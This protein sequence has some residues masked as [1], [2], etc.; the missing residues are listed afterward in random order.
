[1]GFYMEKYLEIG[2]IINKR[3]IK[4][5]LKIE[6]Y[7]N[8]EEDFFE[9]KKIYLSKNGED[10]R[11]IESCK[12][13]RGFV[14]LKISGCS[15]PE[16]ADFLRGKIIYVD[17]D[18]IELPEDEVFI[19]DIIG[20]DVIDATTGVVYGKIK[21]VVN[22]GRYDT[23][24]IK[25]KDKEY[26]MPAVDDFLDRIELDKGVYVTPIEGLFDDGEISENEI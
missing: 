25:G 7:S 1:M 22:Y 15:T 13:Y 26:M 17:R 6:P 23:Y 24:I 20:L 2:K 3:G 5:E 9:Y 12:P 21:D 18:D 10:E 16:Q 19:A 11:K 8:S 14:Y 4:G